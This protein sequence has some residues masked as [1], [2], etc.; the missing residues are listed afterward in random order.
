MTHAQIRKLYLSATK[1]IYDVPELWSSE[2]FNLWHLAVEEM[3]AN[4]GSYLFLMPIKTHVH[5]A[6]I[7]RKTGY[8][9]NGRCYIRYLTKEESYTVPVSKSALQEVL[10]L[11]E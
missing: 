4:N 8:S 5:V 9:D 3:H 7:F 6:Y 11:H 2:N 1:T 10:I